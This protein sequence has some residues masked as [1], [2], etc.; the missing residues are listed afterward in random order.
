MRLC[1]DVNDV[2]TSEANRIT[3]TTCSEVKKKNLKLGPIFLERIFFPV[4][5]GSG[6]EVR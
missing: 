6:Y 2:S 5:F 4:I 1:Q 3:N